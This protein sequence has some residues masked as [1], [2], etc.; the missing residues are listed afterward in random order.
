MTPGGS[1]VAEIVVLSG[2]MNTGVSHNETIIIGV[3]VTR[4]WK[5]PYTS[6]EMSTQFLRSVSN[7]AIWSIRHGIENSTLRGLELPS[8]TR[9]HAP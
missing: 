2:A 9:I 5:E 7:G 4:D 3:N 1:A 6:G 8:E